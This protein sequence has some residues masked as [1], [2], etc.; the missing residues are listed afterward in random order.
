ME[1]LLQEKD[2]INGPLRPPSLSYLGESWSTIH[3]NMQKT[4][5]NQPPNHLKTKPSIPPA[6]AR[7]KTKDNK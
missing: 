7:L 2:E 3:Q 1:E 5:L 4:L 6:H